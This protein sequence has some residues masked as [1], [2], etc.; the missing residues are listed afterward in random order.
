LPGDPQVVVRIAGALFK[1]L[2]AAETAGCGEHLPVHGRASAAARV[3]LPAAP[4]LL[5]AVAGE[6]SYSGEASRVLRC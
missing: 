3:A 6:P 4:R 1:G 5:D 2:R